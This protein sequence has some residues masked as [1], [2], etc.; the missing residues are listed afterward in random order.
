MQ[1]EKR[2]KVLLF[3]AGITA[4]VF[5][6]IPER[7]IEIAEHVYLLCILSPVLFWWVLDGTKRER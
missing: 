6:V 2:D 5:S 7:S 4:V 3:L 1:I